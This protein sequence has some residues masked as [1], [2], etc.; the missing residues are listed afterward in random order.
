M[1]FAFGLPGAATALPS[2]R[3]AS[4][5]VPQLLL[6]R[7]HQYIRFSQTLVEGRD[8]LIFDAQLSEEPF[9]RFLL[10]FGDPLYS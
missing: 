1:D 9:F 3:R 4:S 10:R 6:Q 8:L 2:P 7:D 5:L